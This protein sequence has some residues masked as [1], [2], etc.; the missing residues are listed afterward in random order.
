MKLAGQRARMFLYFRA[1]DAAMV[2]R[3]GMFL[4]LTPKV[5]LTIDFK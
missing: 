4:R 1:S 5:S 2:T 3:T